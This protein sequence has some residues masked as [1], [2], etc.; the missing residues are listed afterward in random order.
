V[1]VSSPPLPTVVIAISGTFYALKSDQ[2][3]WKTDTCTSSGPDFSSAVAADDDFQGV[4]GIVLNMM[5]DSQRLVTQMGAPQ[6]I[7]YIDS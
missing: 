4:G 3:L 1:S 6:P 5:R 7:I 2:T